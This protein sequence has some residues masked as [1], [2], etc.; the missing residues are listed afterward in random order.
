MNANHGYVGYS[1][2]VRAREAEREYLFP[3]TIAVKIVAALAGCTQK[4]AR[5]TLLKRGSDEWHH[6]SKFFNRTEYYDVRASAR[7]LL[8]RDPS[9]ALHAIDF[10][11]R[12]NDDWPHRD[13]IAAE[14]SGETG[15]PAGD[16]INIYH[17]NWS[18]D[19]WNDSLDIDGALES[20]QEKENKREAAKLAAMK[21]EEA[22]LREKRYAP[23]MGAARAAIAAGEDFS[24]R[25]GGLKK[26]RAALILHGGDA[27]WVQNN[28][29][30]WGCISEILEMV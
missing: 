18:E 13:E 22:K 3:L 11:R 20:L 7:F 28:I 9:A 14:I 6:T 1:K 16:I 10:E 8:M 23:I 19:D 30:G 2:S 21:A 12:L 5:E 29:I 25:P 26:S 4:V 24:Q 15:I 17:E 27:E